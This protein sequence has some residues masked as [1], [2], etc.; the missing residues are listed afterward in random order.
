MNHM[1]VFP[2][3]EGACKNGKHSSTPRQVVTV[4]RCWYTAV[5]QTAAVVE[6]FCRSIGKTI[7]VTCRYTLL[8]WSS[9]YTTSPLTPDH[10]VPALFSRYDAA[11]MLFYPT[12]INNKIG[13]STC[14]RE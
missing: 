4:S 10:L 1:F 3:S 2:L 6:Y 14:R 12:K 7:V 13:G 11:I 8:P 9:I 5:A